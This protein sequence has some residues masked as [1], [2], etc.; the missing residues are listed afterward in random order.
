MRSYN[1]FADPITSGPPKP[2]PRGESPETWSEM[3]LVETIRRP[4]A[5]P[6]KLYSDFIGNVDAGCAL[7]EGAEAGAG[8]PGTAQVTIRVFYACTNLKAQDYGLYAEM[9]AVRGTE[10]LYAVRRVWRGKPFPKDAIARVRERFGGWDAW[11]G[12]IG[13]GPGEGAD[14]I[15]R[16]FGFYVSPE[17]HILTTHAVV[18]CCKW[19]RFSSAQ[20][21]LLVSDPVKSLAL[22]R[23]RKK[24]PH[25]AT[26]A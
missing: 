17:G 11:F 12:H 6:G 3:I 5:G 19:L 21:K 22:F 14:R 15:S 10:S 20:A 8:D 24:P 7:G 4:A 16:G 13:T 2:K 18:K 1:A 26:F 23:V 9:K 25:V